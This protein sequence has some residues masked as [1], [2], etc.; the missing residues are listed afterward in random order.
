MEVPILH[1][2]FE[3]GNTF[4]ARVKAGGEQR[5]LWANAS[6]P[7]GQWSTIAFSYQ[8][9][10]GLMSFRINDVETATAHQIVGGYDCGGPGEPCPGRYFRPDRY[11]TRA[12]LSKLLFQA[13]GVP[14][15]G[16]R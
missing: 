4:Q 12:Q 16:R 3:E 2:V 14:G 6:I 8:A 7:V 11:A 9:S 13:F 15:A 10:T 5:S 1:K